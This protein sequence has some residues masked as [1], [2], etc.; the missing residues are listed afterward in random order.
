MSRGQN[1]TTYIT[2]Y[3]T[4]HTISH[5]P[6]NITHITQFH[7]HHTIPHPLDNITQKPNICSHLAMEKIVIVDI[8][9]HF[10]NYQKWTNDHILL[11]FLVYI[12]STHEK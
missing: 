1:Y 9:S 2:Q 6:H 4:H 7:S 8:F 11:W 12:K 5:I 10:D 3:R